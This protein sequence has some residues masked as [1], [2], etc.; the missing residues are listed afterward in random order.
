MIP[1]TLQNIG[2]AISNLNPDDVRSIAARPVVIGLTAS[3]G[4]ALAGMEEYLAPHDVSQQKRVEALRCIYRTSAAE[5]PREFDVELH[6][7]GAPHYEGS[8]PFRFDDPDSTVKDVLKANEN[9]GLPLARRFPVFRSE[10]T[11][12]LIKRISKENALFSLV[13]AMPNIVPSPMELP[14]AVGEFAS[15][16]A[17]L[18]ANQIRMAFLLAAASDR[19]IGYAEQKAEVGGIVAGAFG[20]RA[21]ARELSGKIPLGGGLIPKAAIAY[22][23]TYVVGRSLERLYR[24]GYAF[25]RAERSSEYNQAYE[26]GKHVAGV[27]LQ[28]LKS[29]PS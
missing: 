16:A 3:S 4:E 20:W 22:A 1:R 2:K 25:S 19:E 18:T 10:V 23:G 27:L 13:T 21:I 17:F 28:G 12:Q 11:R 29:R 7:E 15:D 26:R 24:M 5:A 8:F 14:W 9:L 6:E